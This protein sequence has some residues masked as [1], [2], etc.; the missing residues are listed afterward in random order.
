[1]LH[2]LGSVFIMG[3]MIGLGM[4][5]LEKEKQRMVML[6]TWEYITEL[7]LNEITYKKQPLSLASIEIGKKIKGS[8][9]E[10]LIKIGEKLENG[11]E[12][13]FGD[14]WEKEWKNKVREM[15]LSKEEKE[16]VLQFQVFTGYENE[17]IQ[18]NMIQLQQEKWKKIRERVQAESK[19]KKKIVVLLSF[20]VG[21]L[22]VLILL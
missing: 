19:E 16:M 12:D 11:Q 9:G 5:Y 17:E 22:I 13:S 2:L 1:M 15:V 4:H 10:I 6:E 14:I 7:Y 8:Q 3:G 18:R 21:M 20:S